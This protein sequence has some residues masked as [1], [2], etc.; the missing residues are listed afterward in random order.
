[1]ACG[2]SDQM[3]NVVLFSLGYVNCNDFM[4]FSLE[5]QAQLLETRDMGT[6]TLDCICH[7]IQKYESMILHPESAGQTAGNEGHEHRQC[8][9]ISVQGRGAAA[10]GRRRQ[11]RR[12]TREHRRDRGSFWL[13]CFWLCVSVIMTKHCSTSTSRLHPVLISEFVSRGKLYIEGVFAAGPVTGGLA[14]HL[15]T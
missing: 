9:G 15:C 3:P 11:R 14:I 7:L 10:R 2:L 13:P 5:R 6:S 4:Q 1:M 12:V 8:A